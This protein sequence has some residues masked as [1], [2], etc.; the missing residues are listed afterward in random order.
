MTNATKAKTEVAETIK[1]E[2]VDLV[3][4]VPVTEEL[5]PATAP[6]PEPFFVTSFNQTPLAEANRMAREQF[7]AQQAKLDEAHRVALAAVN[8]AF[9]GTGAPMS[10]VE[11]VLVR[12]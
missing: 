7:A 10:V 9:A 2:T 3:S 4:S 5:P 12:K 11:A 6:L 8:K 1:D